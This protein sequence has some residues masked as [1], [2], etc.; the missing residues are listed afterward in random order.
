MIHKFIEDLFK[1]IMTKQP[2]VTNFET[3]LEPYGERLRD[4]LS[5]DAFLA[6][7][8]AVGMQNL[9]TELQVAQMLS[10]IG[11]IATSE[12]MRTMDRAGRSM[13]TLYTFKSVVAG[14]EKYFSKDPISMYWL[15]LNEV[16][17]ASKR[18]GLT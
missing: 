5:E 12:H 7:C 10:K 2:H 14:L 13:A 3:F 9:Y 15:T 1:A 6:A 18:A 4:L 16:Y 8:N 11:M 17:I